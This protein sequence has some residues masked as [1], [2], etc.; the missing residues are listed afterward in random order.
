M[1]EAWLAAAAEQF[2]A[3]VG[4]A[5]EPPRDLADIAPMGYPLAIRSQPEL[6]LSDIYRWLAARNL[7]HAMPCNDRA[8]CGCLIGFRGRGLIFISSDD[9]PAE[10]RFTAGHEVAHF[11]LDYLAPRRHAL[12]ALGQEILPVLDGEREPTWDESIHALLAGTSL[13][14]FLDLMPRAANGEIDQGYILRAEQRADRLALELLAPETLV[15]QMA[16]GDP[17]RAA[18]LLIARFGLPPAVA[19]KY[20][21]WLF[22]GSRRPSLVEWLRA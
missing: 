17:E 20:A 19:H 13:G 14:V 9:P 10:R 6:H 21:A 7:P 12:D 1:I 4:G 5:T 8:L 3:A 16:R 11:L 22:R 18:D 2:W 15:R